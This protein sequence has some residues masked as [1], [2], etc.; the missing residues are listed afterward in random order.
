[1][2]K[3]IVQSTELESAKNVYKKGVVSLE[4]I[5]LKDMPSSVEDAEKLYDEIVKS[6]TYLIDDLSQPY[7]V[8]LSYT[9]N[10]SALRSVDPEHLNEGDQFELSESIQDILTENGFPVIKSD[11]PDAE[12]S[13]EEETAH[14]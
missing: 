3:N 12:K 13:S 11:F 7:M 9:E 8:R 1:M 2:G 14:E 10:K 6:K 4:I 5:K